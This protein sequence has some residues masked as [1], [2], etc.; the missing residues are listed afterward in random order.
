MNGDQCLAALFLEGHR[1]DGPTVTTFVI[2]PDEARVRCNRAR[3]REGSAAVEQSAG[4][5]GGVP[6][7]YVVGDASEPLG[8]TIAPA[9]TG[10][11]HVSAVAVGEVGEG[12]DGHDASNAPT[13]ALIPPRRRCTS[14]SGKR[15]AC[16]IPSRAG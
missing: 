5:F 11:V 7:V 1:G 13:S 12:D 9:S 8:S 4:R 10:C 16:R 14:G 3:A 15:L 2:S 6:Y